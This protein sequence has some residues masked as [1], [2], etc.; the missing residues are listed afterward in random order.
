MKVKEFKNQ[1]VQ[2]DQVRP[3]L[4]KRGNLMNQHHDGDLGLQ[5]KKTIIANFAE[6]DT[7]SDFPDTRSFNENES[8]FK[9]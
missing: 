4:K 3:V 9:F 2:L 6:D 1:Q 5:K 7:P 8:S